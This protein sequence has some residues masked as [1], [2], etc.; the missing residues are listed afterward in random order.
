MV[1]VQCISAWCNYIMDPATNTWSYII[2]LLKRQTVCV[3]G[4]ASVSAKSL[5]GIASQ[6]QHNSS[7]DLAFVLFSES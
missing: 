6:D 2:F 5:D 4:G 1:V 7:A 3:C